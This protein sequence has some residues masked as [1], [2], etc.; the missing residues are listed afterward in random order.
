MALTIKYFDRSIRLFGYGLG[1][2]QARRE[3][4]RA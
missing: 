2:Y 4:Q 3:L 1:P